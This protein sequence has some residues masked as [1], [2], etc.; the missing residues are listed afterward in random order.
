MNLQ[1]HCLR[2]SAEQTTL[3]NLLILFFNLSKDPYQRAFRNFQQTI[4]EKANLQTPS[5]TAQ[6]LLMLK[7]RTFF[8]YGTTH[9]ETYLKFLI[10][11]NGT[12]LVHLHVYI[13]SIQFHIKQN[14]L[15]NKMRHATN[16]S[17]L[18]CLSKALNKKESNFQKYSILV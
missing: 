3:Q 16:T 7:V 10:R 6:K 15:L 2:N 1:L 9:L 12:F 18:S 14:S 8:Y 11:I 17:T 5:I 4:I 13:V